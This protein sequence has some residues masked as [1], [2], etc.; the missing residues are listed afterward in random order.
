MGESLEKELKNGCCWQKMK[1]AAE[2][3]LQRIDYQ[4][5]VYSFL[6]NFLAFFTAV[7]VKSETLHQFLIYK[8]LVL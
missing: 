7:S 4:L 2:N 3:N 6:S 5:A 8:S 1:E